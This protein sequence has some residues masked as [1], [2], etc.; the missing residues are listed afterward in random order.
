MHHKKITPISVILPAATLLL[1]VVAWWLDMPENWWQKYMPLIVATPIATGFH[2]SYV[3]GIVGESITPAVF[4]CMYVL[5][6]ALYLVSSAITLSL[7]VDTVAIILLVTYLVAA[8]HSLYM[9]CMLVPQ[10]A[11]VIK[12][13]FKYTDDT[14]C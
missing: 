6:V 8:V 2:L 9:V 14:A 1:L 3:R 12:F 13:I 4:S 10:A 11:R 7:G 5:V